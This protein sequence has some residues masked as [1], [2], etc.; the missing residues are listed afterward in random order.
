MRIIHLCRIRKGRSSGGALAA[1]PAAAIGL[2][3]V[4]VAAGSAAAAAEDT[5]GA[6]QRK[7]G[8]SSRWRCV[9]SRGRCRR[10]VRSMVLIVV[11]LSFAK[12]PVRE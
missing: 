7:R 10:R 1:E 2:A 11:R 6:V 3:A 12:P 9:I 5:L 4:A 8:W